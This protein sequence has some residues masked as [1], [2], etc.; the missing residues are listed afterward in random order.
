[1]ALDY[2]VPELNYRQTIYTVAA[3]EAVNVDARHGK[4][5]ISVICG[6]GATATLNRIAAL[7]ATSAVDGDAQVACG[8]GVTSTPLDWPFY[9]VVV[10]GG[11]ATVAVV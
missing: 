6:A 4:L 1:M 9:R 10:S 7:D 11:T 2:S 3:G 5:N 8:A